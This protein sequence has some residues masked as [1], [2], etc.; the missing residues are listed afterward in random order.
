MPSF[1][2]KMGAEYDWARDGERYGALDPRA[3]PAY[4]RVMQV[5]YGP[6]SSGLATGLGGTVG[7]VVGM[8]EAAGDKV[9]DL[10][11]HFVD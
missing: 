2:D 3:T 10:W 1:W 6:D 9:S 11:H 4:D 8:A 7:G 5:N